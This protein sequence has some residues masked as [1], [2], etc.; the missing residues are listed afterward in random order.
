[1]A[2]EPSTVTSTSG[3][4]RPT[5]TSGCGPPAGPSAAGLLRTAGFSDEEAARALLAV[6]QYT[7]GHTLEEQVAVDPSDAGALGPAVLVEAVGAGDYPHLTATFTS[8]DFAPQFAFGLDLLV[9]G[10]AARRQ[11]HAPTAG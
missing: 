10:L 3:I 6:T 1:M 11:R 9:D 4:R 5:R 8:L 7:V 2:A